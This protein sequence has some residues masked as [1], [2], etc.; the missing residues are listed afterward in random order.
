MTTPR[1]PDSPV[2]DFPAPVSLAALIPMQRSASPEDRTP[3]GRVM[4]SP[5]RVTAGRDTRLAVLW[6]LLGATMGVLLLVAA[7]LLVPLI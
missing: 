2:P 7:V 3:V 5:P 4:V 1:L 6:T